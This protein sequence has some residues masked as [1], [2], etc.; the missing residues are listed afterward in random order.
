MQNSCTLHLQHIY[1]FNFPRGR[2]GTQILSLSFPF[3]VDFNATDDADMLYFGKNNPEIMSNF[4][5][6]TR[7]K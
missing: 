6:I 4:L 7:L 5:K 3:S 2:F 1:L